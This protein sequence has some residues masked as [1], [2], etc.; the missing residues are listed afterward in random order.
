[1]W[2]EALDTVATSGFSRL[3]P[4]QGPYNLRMRSW[5]V[6]LLLVCLPLQWSWAGSDV[7]ERHDGGTTMVLS[8]HAVEAA[9][10]ANDP[11]ANTH[12][13]DCGGCHHGCSLALLGAPRAMHAVAQVVPAARATAWPASRPADLPER[14]Q[15]RAVALG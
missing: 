2:L 5:L 1:M 15:W 13:A 8:S 6:V 12:T 4:E 3:A 10:A 7:R 14:P 11:H 9:D